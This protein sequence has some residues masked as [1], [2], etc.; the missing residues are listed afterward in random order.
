MRLKSELY[1]KEQLEILD[2]I[3]AILNI[4]KQPAM[5]LLD[6]DNDTEKQTAIMELLPDVYKYF[7]KSYIEG[8]K[9][10]GRVKRPWLSIAK[11]ILK[12]KYTLVTSGYNLTLPNGNRFQ[13]VKYYFVR[14]DTIQQSAPTIS[15]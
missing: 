15:A 7:S 1:K 11:A 4:N 10:P 8:A 9:R 14:T 3:V 5:T 2:K 12:L 6:L 13:T